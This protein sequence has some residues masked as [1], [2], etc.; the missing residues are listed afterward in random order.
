MFESEKLAVLE[1]EEGIV[2][3]RFDARNDSVN[4]FDRQTINELA[5]ALKVLKSSDNIK[6]L[7]VT[8]GKPVFIVGAD[9]M[10][11]STLD[12]KGL[13]EVSKLNNANFCNL[14]DLPFP[15]VVA[16]NGFALG[17]GFEL[18]MSCD[19]RVM[20]DAAQVGLPETKLG[21]I[22]GWGGTVRL[23]RLIGFDNAVEWIAAGQHKRPADAIKDG[24]VDA[25]VAADHLEQQALVM[26]KQAING[27]LEIKERRARKLS[28]LQLNAIEL[29]M[30]ATTC[31]AMVASKAGKNYPAPV[32][33]V[34][35]MAKA[36]S[37]DRDGALVEE[38]LA[39]GAIG[40]TPQCKAMIGLFLSDQYLNKVA[41]KYSKAAKQ[42]IERAAVL[43]AG[44]MGGG[45]AYQHA[46]KGYPILMKDIA[47]PALDMGMAEAN[48]LF[49][50][51]V[52][53][54]R[55]TPLKAGEALTRITPTLNSS[56]LDNVDLVIE[57][58]VENPAV[59]A[60]VLK[61]TE[62]LIRE[63][64]ILASN[65]S[66]I[67][68]SS[69]ADNLQRPD[70]FCG[71]HFFN[72]VH[73]MPLVEVIRGEK[74]SDETVSA[75]VAHALSLGKKP[76]VV[77]DCPG[78]LINR[79]LFPAVI[80]LDH[81]LK[82][83]GDFQQIDKV[84]EKWGWPMGPAYLMDVVG[85]DTAVHALKVMASG[86]P[87][88]MSGTGSDS[89]LLKLFEAKRY[90]Q[91]NGV[92]F[93]QYEADK[94]GKPQKLVDES[95]YTLL[96]TEIK[97]L[98]EQ[99]I[100]ASFMVPMCTE[101]ARCLEEGIVSSAAEAD[102]AMIYGVGFPPFRGGIFRWLDEIGL[103]AFIAMAEPLKD[104]GELYHAT[105]TMKSMAANGENYYTKGA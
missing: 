51:R 78:F 75:V 92:G 63:D 43:G 79:V 102:M 49:N 25:V 1:R 62:T 89:P 94:R 20:S 97:P 2:E 66:T 82:S 48:K 59:K 38:S 83:G 28:R 15:T 31:R 23:P 99:Q 9:I 93:Y 52:E 11:L 37:L 69:L 76:V 27:D 100:I 40:S 35:V 104:L 65:T 32:A 21:I 85:I 46:L 54:G 57:A 45:I 95:V 17:G 80:G 39:F 50:K 103:D 26:L 90:G 98:D 47:Q 55:L 72:P 73:A 101:M 87:E 24:A 7:L 91:K 96:G 5:D 84:L 16:I 71:M 14:E 3:L 64:A 60:S 88:R 56:G 33:A 4:K 67:S 53:K 81:L 13:T 36:A 12:E 30:A 41:K 22:P 74:T 8:S 34:D 44:I 58:V 61:E 86:F 42:K 70:K 68:I 6:G 19:F 105:E 77:K 29:Q 10:E 18:C